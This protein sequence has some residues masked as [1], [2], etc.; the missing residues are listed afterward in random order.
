MQ[1]QPS[2]AYQTRTEFDVGLGAVS[3]GGWGGGQLPLLRPWFHPLYIFNFTSHFLSS[4]TVL[5]IRTSYNLIKFPDSRELIQSR[6]NKWAR[7]V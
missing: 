2:N 4:N 3:G 5:V 6:I 7:L 1:T